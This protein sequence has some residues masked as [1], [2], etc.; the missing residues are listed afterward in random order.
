MKTLQQCD[1]R[2]YRMNEI[3]IIQTGA[4]V[5]KS[6]LNE[7]RIPRIT[8]TDVNNGVDL[9]S[10]NSENKNFRTY[11]NCVSI[12]FLGSC[13]YQPYKASYDMKIHNITLRDRPFNKYIALFVAN[14]CK[15]TCSQVTYGNQ[16]SSTDLQNQFIYLP[17]TPNGEPDYAFMEEYMRQKEQT[18]L[19]KYKVYISNILDN[20]SLIGGGKSSNVNWKEFYFT[21]VFTEIQR[22]KRLKRADHSNGKMPY[23]SSTA[24]CNGVDGFVGN[25]ESVNIFSN[26][27]TIAN[28]GSVGSAFFHSYE[29]VASDHVTKLQNEEVSKYAYLFM[30]PIINRLAE[31]YSFNREINDKRIKRERFVLPATPDGTPDFAYMDAYMRNIELQQL[32]K[33]LQH[34]KTCCCS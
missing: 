20:Q 22:G 21:D 25:T 19:A 27:I 34:Y 31:K 29:F 30:L 24:L 15:R 11:E 14:Q 18:I 8:A 23:V 6:Y 9:F 1:W 7:G 32:L 3:F 2:A 16:M 13:F 33:Y 17:S 26:C 10:N 5:S 28:S 12:S 4:N